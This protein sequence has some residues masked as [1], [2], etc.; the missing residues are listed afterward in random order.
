MRSSLE[1]R[2]K[3]IGDAK[4]GEIKAIYKTRTQIGTQQCLADNIMQFSESLLKPAL[5]ERGSPKIAGY[6]KEEGEL[7]PQKE[8]QADASSCN[9]RSAKERTESIDHQ[10]TDQYQRAEESVTGKWANSVEMD[11]NQQ[12]TEES[13]PW[14]I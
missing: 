8:A 9:S 2:E 13:G 7:T 11:A 5:A 14:L 12:A 3:A 1:S 6:G 10:Q 4:D